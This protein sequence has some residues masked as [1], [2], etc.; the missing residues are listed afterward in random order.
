MA[1]NLTVT[2]KNGAGITVT[3]LLLSGI[4]SFSVDVT[5]FMLTVVQDSV[6]MQFDIRAA[7]TFTVAISGA[8]GT[9][10]ITIS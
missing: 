5:T 3:A 2:G 7:T 6:T 10:T 8:G 9:Y 4:T 1:G